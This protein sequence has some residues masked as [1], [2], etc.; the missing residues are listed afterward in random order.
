[1]IEITQRRDGAVV[2]TS[3]AGC[4]DRITERGIRWGGGSMPTVPSN[5]RIPSVPTPGR[6]FRVGQGGV[7]VA[8]NTPPATSTWSGRRRLK[9]G[10]DV[11]D[12]IFDREAEFLEQLTGWSRL[13]E[14]IQ[15]QHLAIASCVLPPAIGD[16]CLDGQALG[17]SR[18]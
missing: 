3:I 14:A 6:M 13:A 10:F 4:D 5:V 11:F 16:T 12:D 2:G 1:M 17:D 7:L 18:W 15:T 9:N 8:P